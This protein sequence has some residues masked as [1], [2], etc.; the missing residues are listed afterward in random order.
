QSLSD[1]VKTETERLNRSLTATLD[2][3]REGP[4]APA[5]VALENA[6]RT[7]VQILQLSP[8]KGSDHSIEVEVRGSAHWVV[9]SS[10]EVKQVLWN[11][12]KNALEAMPTGG[13]LSLCL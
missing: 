13:K 8:D 9:M 4:P 12:A 3:L 1:I 6:L 11:L 10:E 7:F 2:G 5:L